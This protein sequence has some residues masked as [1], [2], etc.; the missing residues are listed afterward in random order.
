MRY[1]ELV[2]AS[3]LLLVTACES[4]PPDVVQTPPVVETPP[5]DQVVANPPVAGPSDLPGQD[6]IDS[7]IPSDNGEDDEVIN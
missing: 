2:V 1:L 5:P 4:I 7:G 6:P 3:L